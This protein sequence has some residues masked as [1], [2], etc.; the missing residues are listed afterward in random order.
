M[1]VVR[2]ILFV[3]GLSIMTAFLSCGLS[4]NVATDS[5]TGLSVAI[6]ETIFPPGAHG[7]R[8]EKES[9]FS[10]ERNGKK[11]LLYYSGDVNSIQIFEE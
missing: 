6:S 7:I 2:F 5:L 11:Y 3:S 4:K 9:W 8:R 10:F 1:K